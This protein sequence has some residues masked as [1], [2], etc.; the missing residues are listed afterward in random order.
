MQEDFEEG[1]WIYIDRGKHVTKLHERQELA[2]ESSMFQDSDD[3]LT[4]DVATRKFVPGFYV[5]HV[6]ETNVSIVYAYGAANGDRLQQDSAR[7]P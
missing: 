2:A 3:V 5:Q 1:T 7:E 6:E 4:Q